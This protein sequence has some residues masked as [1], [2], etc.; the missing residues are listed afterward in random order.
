MKRVYTDSRFP[1]VE[2]VNRGTVL[3]EVNVFKKSDGGFQ[4][5]EHPQ[6]RTVSEAFARRRAESYFEHR[7]RSL[8][9]EDRTLLLK[10]TDEPSVS[11]VV[12]ER[13]LSR[14]SAE[15]DKEKR[16]ALEG[17]ALRLIAREESMAE[18]VVNHLLYDC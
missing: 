12:V 5:R 2:V 17:H 1:G 14:V 7:H 4:A 13:A 18:Q 15:R 10:K 9:Q 11:P 16:R 6:S 3:F 8:L